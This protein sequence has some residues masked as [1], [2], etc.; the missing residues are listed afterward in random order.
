MYK[1]T[2]RKCYK[3]HLNIEKLELTVMLID[4]KAMKKYS[5]PHCSIELNVSV[6]Y[7][8]KYLRQ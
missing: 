2:I 6:S 1:N 5:D 4:D 8:I 3:E 7:L